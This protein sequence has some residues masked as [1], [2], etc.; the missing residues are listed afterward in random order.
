MTLT[1]LM[2][3]SHIWKPNIP[4]IKSLCKGIQKVI[5]R[6]DRQTDRQT[7]RQEHRYD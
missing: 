2:N 4:K 1:L 7:H 6:T 5:A 3:C